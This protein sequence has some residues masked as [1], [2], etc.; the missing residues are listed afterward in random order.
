MTSNET[1]TGMLQF[2]LIFGQR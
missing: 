1:T 2:W